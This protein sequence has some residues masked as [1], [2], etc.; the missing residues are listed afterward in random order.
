MSK[1]TLL[2]TGGGVGWPEVEHWMWPLFTERWGN[3]R[4]QRLG[5]PAVPFLAQADRQQCLPEPPLLLYC[6]SPCLIKRLPTWPASVQVQSSM[7]GS[8]LQGD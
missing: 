1:M 4:Q 6:L 2:P 5:L 8:W 7:H 3:W